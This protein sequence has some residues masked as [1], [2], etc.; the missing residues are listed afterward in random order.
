MCVHCIDVL[1]MTVCRCEQSE[2]SSSLW[3]GPAASM[4]WTL[5]VRHAHLTC[6]LMTCTGL[7]SCVELVVR[8]TV[9]TGC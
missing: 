5:Q 1:C 7:Y 8:A 6:E 3:S 2:V 9:D 4:V